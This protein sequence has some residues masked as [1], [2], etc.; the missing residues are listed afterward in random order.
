V[1]RKAEARGHRSVRRPILGAAAFVLAIAALAAAPAAQAGPAPSETTLTPVTLAVPSTPRWYPG[2]DGRVHLSYELELTNTLPV[3]V[4]AT[5]VEV[6][7]GRGH[8]VE[9]LSNERLTAAMTLL[10]GESEPASRLPASSVGVV[11][12][13]LVFDTRRQVPAQV[14]HRLTVDLGPG[15]PIPPILT[16][17]GGRAQV[18]RK[19]PIAIA[20]PL[21]GGPWV[22]VAGPTG[23]HR[24]AFLD[25]DG[26][27][28]VFRSFELEGSPPSLAACLEADPSGAPDPVDATARG[29][30]RDQGLTGLEIVSFPSARGRG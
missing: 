7:D 5:A 25:A 24:R 19:A 9:T 16:Y 12:L 28:F 20:P 23:P 1:R 10:G 3:P 15:L 21:L 27:P 2:D 22:A 26:L 17:A 11:W 13:D 29:T 4:D 18:A 14:D 6:T 8:R 30:R